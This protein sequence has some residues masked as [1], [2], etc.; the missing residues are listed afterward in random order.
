MDQLIVADW[1]EICALIII[2]SPKNFTCLSD[3]MV[4]T[5]LALGSKGIRAHTQLKQCCTSHGLVS[6]ASAKLK[7]SRQSRH[8]PADVTEQDGPRRHN[9]SLHLQWMSHLLIDIDSVYFTNRCSTFNCPLR[10]SNDIWIWR[11]FKCYLGLNKFGYIID[12]TYYYLALTA[13]K[14]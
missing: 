6:L 5:L 1:L 9:H 8:G 11:H 2:G 3:V 13:Y 10:R 14:H 12:T 7:L 4:V